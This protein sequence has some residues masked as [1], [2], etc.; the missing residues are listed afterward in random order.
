MLVKLGVMVR[1]GAMVINIQADSV[2]IK[3]GDRTESIPT[4]TVLWAAGVLASPLGRTFRKKRA[5]RS[6]MPA[7]WL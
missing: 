6:T 7:A 5:Q 3:E 2:T 4:R 1:T